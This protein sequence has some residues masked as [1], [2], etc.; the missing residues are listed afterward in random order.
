MA[1]EVV[2]SWS[3]GKDAALALR[4]LR[5]AP[6][7]EVTGL[8]TTVSA[9]TGRTTMHGVRR[10]LIRAQAE[11]LGLP[12]RAVD[13]PEPC[14]NEDYERI[15][16][17]AYA[18]CADAGV[19]AVAF[20]D[21]HLESVREYREAHLAESPLAG[22]WPVWGRDTGSFFEAVLDAGVRALVCCVDAE[23]LDASV[24]GRELDRSLRE[25]LPASVDPCGERGAFHTFVVDG[26]GFDRPVG[27]ECGETA[28]KD[29]EG[30]SYHYLDL[31]PADPP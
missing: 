7:T 21:L 17:E 29:L 1:T 2:L 30:R 19:E 14:P 15:L 23:A 8:L 6:D 5:D 25:S 11:A 22:A 4:V 10:D 13:L 3:G 24:L 27:V 9:E 31:L 16:N 28:T 20:A 26:P 18:E 12:L